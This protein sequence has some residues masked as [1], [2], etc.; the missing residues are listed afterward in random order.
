MILLGLDKCV[1][2]GDEGHDYTE[3]PIEQGAVVEIPLD[4]YRDDPNL[5]TEE[6]ELHSAVTVEEFCSTD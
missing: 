4:E 5:P 3:A 2:I 1:I 6:E